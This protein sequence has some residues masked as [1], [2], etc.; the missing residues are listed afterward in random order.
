MKPEYFRIG[1]T[2]ILY[3]ADTLDQVGDHYFT[4]SGWQQRQGLDGI[5][6]GRGA[7]VF[8]HDEDGEF[9]LRHYRRG[10]FI[11]KVNK[12]CYLWTGLE[13]SRPWREWHLLDQMSRQGLPV[14]KPVAARLVH[15]GLCYVAD[16][17]MTRIHAP[18]LAQHLLKTPLDAASWE[19]VGACIRRFHDAGV[20]HADL[21][22]HN[23]L[24]TEDNEVWLI[25]F[26]RGE[27][28]QEG[29]WKQTNLDR[30]Q[31]SLR[32]LATIHIE[33]NYREADWDLLLVGYS[34]KA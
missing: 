6:C 8:V 3:D 9:V 20:H 25:D 34:G 16:I 26:D 32:K 12:D 29:V 1:E 19:A 27:I 23:I 31:R 21:N 2:H 24:L 22:A 14:P 7:T 4:L 28:R 13:R 17:L 30:L 5:A 10:G 11:A 33:F 15:H 18:S